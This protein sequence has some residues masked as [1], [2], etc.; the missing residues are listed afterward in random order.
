MTRHHECSLQ[1]GAQNEPLF[2]SGADGDDS[3]WRRTSTT[4]TCRICQSRVWALFSF[5]IVYLCSSPS[6]PDIYA[7]YP[8]PSGNLSFTFRYHDAGL[9]HT[10]L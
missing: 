10:V 9:L 6:F 7:L 8:Y 4:G 3:L 1:L 2:W 5:F